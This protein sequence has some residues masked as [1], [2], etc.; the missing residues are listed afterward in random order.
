MWRE[1]LRT[2]DLEFS[3][4]SFLKRTWTAAGLAAFFERSGPELFAAA[5]DIPYRVMGAMGDLVIPVDEDPGYRTFDPEISRYALDGF[6]QHVVLAGARGGLDLVKGALTAMNNAPV[7]VDYGP[8]FLD[9][10]LGQREQY[11]TDCLAG[12]FEN[13]GYGDLLGFASFIG[14][15]VSKAVFF[16]NFPNHLANEGEEFQIFKASSIRTGFDIMGFRGPIGKKEEDALREKFLGI[17]VLPG[18]DRSNPFL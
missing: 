12:N 2:V 10:R 5:E 11:F 1:A 9:M 4:R 15:F 18:I 7:E 14:L 13:D 3:R 6:V 8:R 17:E 16:S